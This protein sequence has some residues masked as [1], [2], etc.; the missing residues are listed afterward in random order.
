MAVELSPGRPGSA[1]QPRAAGAE[2]DGEALSWMGTAEAIVANF[3]L[4]GET[5][6]SRA[7]VVSEHWTRPLLDDR[8][9]TR[10]VLQPDLSSVGGS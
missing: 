1:Q 8:G 9:I 4:G 7:A 6:R 5:V 10:Q 2:A 3:E